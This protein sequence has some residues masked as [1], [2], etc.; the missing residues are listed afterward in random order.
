MLQALAASF[1]IRLPPGEVPA[2]WAESL[3][4]AGLVASTASTGP[5]V[6]VVAEGSNWRVRAYDGRGATRELVVAAP[7]SPGAREDVAFLAASLVR[8]LASAA[9]AAATAPAAAAAAP[10]GVALAAEARPTS[11]LPP[12]T[13]ATTTAPRPP[14][15]PPPAAPSPET[16]TPAPAAATATP[17]PAPPTE[18][19]APVPPAPD[20]AVATPTVVIEPVVDPAVVAPPAGWWVGLGATGA[21]AVRTDSA[22]APAVGGRFEAGRGRWAGTLRASWAA[23]ATMQ[24]LEAQPRVAETTLAAGAE[25]LPGPAS[26][27]AH[28]GAVLLAVSSAEG[29][30]LGNLV[31]APVVGVDAGWRV[32]PLDPLVV[33]PFVGLSVVTRKVSLLTVAEGK[34]TVEPWR[35]RLG[36][37]VYFFAGSS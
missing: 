3:A 27:G 2:D 6:E 4:M 35:L 28:A 22:V 34:S 24:A 13:A 16:A 7:R 36:V 12:P 30:A 1:A 32:R 26:V 9:A 20:A 5:R 21:A 8:P 23:P 18:S 37:A 17:S 14:A 31:V 19:A 15:A 29:S 25:W 33:E 10:P 11:P